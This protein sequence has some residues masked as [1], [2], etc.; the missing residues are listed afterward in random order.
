MSAPKIIVR[1]SAFHS[2]MFA[3]IEKIYP[4]A[5][6]TESILVLHKIAWCL[7]APCYG[8]PQIVKCYQIYIYTSEFHTS[9]LDFLSC[10]HCVLQAFRHKDHWPSLRCLPWA[11]NPLVK[12]L[13]IL[14]SILSGDLV[15]C[16]S[17]DESLM[18]RWIAIFCTAELPNSVRSPTKRRSTMD[19]RR[20][21][22]NQMTLNSPLIGL[23]LVLCL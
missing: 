22:E 17:L 19:P 10:L 1:V 21:L 16:C 20:V 11:T 13:L 5:R 2:A 18:N 23:L 9:I 3:R 15:F 8:I 6:S 4:Y 14:L 12:R 7:Q